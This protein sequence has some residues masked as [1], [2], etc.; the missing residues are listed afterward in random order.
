MWYNQDSTYD[1]IWQLLKFPCW[2]PDLYCKGW[3]DVPMIKYWSSE[4]VLE[5]EDTLYMKGIG[6]KCGQHGRCWLPVK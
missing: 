4:S 1:K 3:V 6:C 5:K 2:G